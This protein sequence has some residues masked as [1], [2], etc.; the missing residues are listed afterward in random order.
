MLPLGLRNR[1]AELI[2]DAFDDDDAR[3]TLEALAAFCQPGDG[4][5]GAAAASRLVGL[6]WF[7][8]VGAER[9]RLRGAHRQH[10]QALCG[11]A[12]AALDAIRRAPTGG[13]PLTLFRRLE[14]AARLADAGLYFEVHELLE[15]AWLASCEDLE[16]V[17]LQG[18]IQVA[19]ALNHATCGNREGAI[20]LLGEGLAKLA[21]ARGALPLDTATWEAALAA[22]LTALR[23]GAA[24][25][26]LFPWPRPVADVTDPRAGST[27]RRGSETN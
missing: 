19:V 5:V 20:S 3:R 27:E 8:V 22:A 14:R 1:L 23:E 11:R 26:T 9:V 18:L 4:I 7:D 12:M 25:P 2:L 13:A 15:P 16:R 10:G 24:L 17:A 21:A 6:G